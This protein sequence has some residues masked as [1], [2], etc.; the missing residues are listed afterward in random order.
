MTRLVLALAGRGVRRARQNRGDASMQAYPNPPPHIPDTP[1]ARDSAMHMTPLRTSFLLA[2][3]L[4]TLSGCA[5]APA[6]GGNE[7]AV[8]RVKTVVV[9]FAENH[10]FDNLYGLY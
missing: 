5:N 4:A 6:I 2:A 8:Q 7:A 1:L 10:S 9:I 3:I